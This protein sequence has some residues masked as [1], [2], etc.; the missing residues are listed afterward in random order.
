MYSAFYFFGWLADLFLSVMLWFIFDTKKN[1]S[2]IM[3][4][5]KVYIV[6]NVLKDTTSAINID[7]EEEE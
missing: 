7:C 1:P 4:G 3:D 2:I 5:N 6:T